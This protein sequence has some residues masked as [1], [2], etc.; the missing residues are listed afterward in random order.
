M[1]IVLPLP[2]DVNGF[3]DGLTKPAVRS[4]T[5]PLPAMTMRPLSQAVHDDGSHRRARVYPGGH[6]NR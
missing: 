1:P 6:R 3:K 4:S 2:G 5:V